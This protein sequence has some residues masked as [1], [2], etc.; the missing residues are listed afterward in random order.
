MSDHR[1]RPFCLHHVVDW[2]ILGNH[3]DTE[4]LST[5]LWIDELSKYV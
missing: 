1:D 2:F 4:V 3:E 5:L